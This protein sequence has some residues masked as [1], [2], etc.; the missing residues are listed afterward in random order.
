MIFLLEQNFKDINVDYKSPIISILKDVQ[1]FNSS[2][3]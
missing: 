3:K 2:K 1:T